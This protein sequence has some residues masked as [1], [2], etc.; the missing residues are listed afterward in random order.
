MT[1]VEV[2]DVKYEEVAAH[3]ETLTSVKEEVKT[4]EEPIHNDTVEQNETVIEETKEE[5]KEDASPEACK[6]HEAKPTA[7]AKA[8]L[9]PRTEKTVE[10][11]EC[12][13]CVKK[14]T[15]KSFR[16][17][18]PNYCKGAPTEQLEVKPKPIRRIQPEVISEIKNEIKQEVIKETIQKP[19]ATELLNQQ[20]NST[21]N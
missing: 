12:E 2:V 17:T 15:A 1:S 3:L 21:K 19:T 6:F 8:Q 7:K 9:K 14:M 13:K 11:V 16:F 18:H 10:Q 20:I 5:V 4:E